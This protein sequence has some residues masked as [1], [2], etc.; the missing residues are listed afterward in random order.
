MIVL[1]TRKGR[2]AHRYHVRLND[3]ICESV[4]GVWALWNGGPGIV[5]QYLKDISG[6]L[7]LDIEGKTAARAYRLGIVHV[8]REERTCGV[9]TSER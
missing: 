3:E 2:L 9:R 7:Y 8:R 5:G 6:H 4:F 1:D